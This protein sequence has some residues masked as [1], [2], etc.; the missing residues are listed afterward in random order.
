M[1]RIHTK[2]YAL[3][4][5]LALCVTGL[6]NANTIVTFQV[7]MTQQIANAAFTPGVNVVNARGSFNGWGTFQ[8]T[9]NPSAS[10]TN[11][12]TGVINDTSDANGAL[13]NYKF[14]IDSGGWES[15]NDRQVGLPATSGASLTVPSC[16]FNDATPP[17]VTVNNNITFQVDMTQ[18][19]A[20]G[21]FIP[22]T[23]VVSVRGGINGWGSTAMTNNPAGANTNLYSMT[24]NQVDAPINLEHFKFF[25][26][27]GNNWESPSIPSE[28]GREGDLNRYYN[29]LAAD[30]NVVL[31]PVYFNDIA[32]APP[33]TNIV[34]FTVDMSV[35]TALGRFVP[36]TD[37]VECR[38]SF[39]N[40]NV[41]AFV[42]TNNPA[43]SNTNLYSG[44]ATLIVPPSTISYKFWDSDAKAGNNGYESPASTGGGNRTYTLANSNTSLTIPTVYYSDLSSTEDFLTAD[45]LVTFTVSMTNAITTG[46]IPFN[47]VTDKV[48]LNGD[49]VPWWAWNDPLEPY[50]PYI[51]TNGTSGDQLYSGTFLV[52]K[53]NSLQLTY[54]FSINGADNELPAYVNHVRY[55]RNLNTYSTPLDTFG[56]QGTEPPLGKVTVGTPAGGNIPVAWLGLPSAYLQSATSVLGPWTSYPAT[57]NNGSPSGIYSTNF[58]MSGQALYFRAVQP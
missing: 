29:M 2:Q 24:L 18:Q 58:P 5:G 15:G 37:T 7:D 22:G 11:L 25:I 16:Y 34:T 47:P 10:N 43:A 26:D 51:L 13:M 21:A 48:Y 46:G 4:A 49:W 9:N 19:V 30:G 12:Y 17:G 57:V 56:T 44:T 32:P 50:A 6:A 8:L 52:P 54:K 33:I 36:S 31:P 35:Q 55:V 27:T 53:G 1:K 42:L 39:N 41:G 23:S 20:I 38:G 14:C 3:W 45:T 28:Q 40:W